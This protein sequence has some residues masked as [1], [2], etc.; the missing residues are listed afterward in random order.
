MQRDPQN[1]FMNLQDKYK[2][3]KYVRL[4][5]GR[6]RGKSI[7]FLLVVPRLGALLLSILKDE[8]ET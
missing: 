8:V 7:F 2:R 6:W 1:E 5:V 4:R 3:V